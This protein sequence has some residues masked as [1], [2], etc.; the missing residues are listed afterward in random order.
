MVGYATAINDSLAAKPDNDK[1]LV[2]TLMDK[3]KAGRAEAVKKTARTAAT[4]GSAVTRGRSW[5]GNTI[6]GSADDIRVLPGKGMPLQGSVRPS[7]RG[8]NG[9]H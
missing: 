2:A 8:P 3:V 9:S 5:L 4:I 6:K 7:H 1:R